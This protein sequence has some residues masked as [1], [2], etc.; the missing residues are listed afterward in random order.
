M[1]SGTLDTDRILA[2]APVLSHYKLVLGWS[3][4][5]KGVVQG[6]PSLPDGREIVTSQL[7]YLDPN[8]GLARTLSRWYRVTD[9]QQRRGS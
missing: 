5:L 8:L 6:H 2:G 4:A 7:I 1:E 9:P 3:H